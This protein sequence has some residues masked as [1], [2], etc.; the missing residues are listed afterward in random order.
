MGLYRG[1]D[2]VVLGMGPKMAI[3]FTSFEGFK[4]LGTSVTGQSTPNGSVV[5]LA[6]LAA[7][8]TESICVVN[9]MKVVKIRLQGQNRVGGRGISAMPQYRNAFDAARCVIQNQGISSLCRGVS[10]AATSQGTN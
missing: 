8:I 5:F 4:H 7:G 9:P 6:G 3:R 10:L 1:F 2:A